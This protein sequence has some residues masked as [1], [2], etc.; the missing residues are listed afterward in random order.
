[1]LTGNCTRC[2]APNLPGAKFCRGC[3]APAATPAVATPP[4][5]AFPPASAMPMTMPAPTYGPVTGPDPTLAAHLMPGESINFAFTGRSRFFS[6]YGSV[7]VTAGRVLAIVYSSGP[8]AAS[9][10]VRSF[11][12]RPSVRHIAVGAR[13]EPIRIIVGFL[14][15]IG[16][17][18]SGIGVLANGS[19]AGVVALV[20]PCL[21]GA[22]M[23]YYA[24]Q[25][26]LTIHDLTGA[27]TR[28]PLKR[29][30]I[31]AALE[32]AAAFSTTLGSLH[33]G[34]HGL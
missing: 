25:G 18:V 5:S 3:G 6:P 12:D 33:T 28:I 11:R 27:F 23:I 15:V 9:S 20:V 29:P 21:I 26:S 8:E 4:A 2:G 19:P 7:L 30:D 17:L 13:T 16:G 14:F 32:F 1:M 10:N 24:R 22:L 34:P 31:P